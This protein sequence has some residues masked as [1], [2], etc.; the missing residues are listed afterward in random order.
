M[1]R[2]RF[3]TH[4]GKRILLVDLTNCSAGDVMKIAVQ[5]QR[6]VTAQLRNST[7]ILS[8]LTGVQFSR[9]A[10]TRI[11]EVAVFDRPYV[12]RAA[13][14]GAESLPNCL[15]MKVPPCAKEL[16]ACSRAR[17]KS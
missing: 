5:A 13:I 4:Q 8:D 2:I 9:D 14:V 3:I 17:R 16:G 12:K 1:D 11:K 7:L 15:A 6:I 10:V